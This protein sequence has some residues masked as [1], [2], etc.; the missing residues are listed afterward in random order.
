MQHITDYK[1]VQFYL[2]INVVFLFR[3]YSLIIGYKPKRC[4]LFT[5]TVCL[6]DCK[7]KHVEM[8]KT[9]LELLPEALG[10]LPKWIS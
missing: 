4:I 6:C 9:K 3:W 7:Y 2:N 10:F 1:T 5:H 8:S